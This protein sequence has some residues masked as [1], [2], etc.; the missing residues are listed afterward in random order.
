[1]EKQIPYKQEI[2]KNVAILLWGKIDFKTKTVTRHTMIKRSINQE[3]MI[4]TDIYYL[5]PKA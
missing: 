2:K 4:I 1:M 3:Y 5:T